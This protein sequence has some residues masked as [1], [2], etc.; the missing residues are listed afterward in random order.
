MLMVAFIIIGII[1]VLMILLVVVG[2][3]WQHGIAKRRHQAMLS[4]LAPWVSKLE[5]M[6]AKQLEQEYRRIRQL[7]MATNEDAEK[8]E[9][10]FDLVCAETMHRTER[11]FGKHFRYYSNKPGLFRQGRQMFGRGRPE[12]DI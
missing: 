2:L 4:E 10:Q 8:L 5:K 7:W 11:Q 3:F 12:D 9:L 1:V 6:D